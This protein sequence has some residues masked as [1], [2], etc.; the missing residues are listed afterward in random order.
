MKVSKGHYNDARFGTHLVASVFIHRKKRH[1]KILPIDNMGWKPSGVFPP[2]NAKDNIAPLLGRWYRT[3]NFGPDCKII[4]IYFGVETY[5]TMLQVLGEPI[6]KELF[7]WERGVDVQSICNYLNDLS[8][9]N[10]GTSVFVKTSITQTLEKFEITPIKSINTY[11]ECVNIL[12]CYNHMRKVE[13][14]ALGI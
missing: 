14:P 5:D 2:F 6:T 4:P 11:S 7:I 9:E 12:N 10:F 3:C 8:F 13:I 1:L